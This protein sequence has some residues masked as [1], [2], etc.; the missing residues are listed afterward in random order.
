MIQMISNLDKSNHIPVDDW[1]TELYPVEDSD[2][3]FRSVRGEIILPFTDLFNHDEDARQLNYFIMTT[4][5]GYNSDKTREHICRYLNYFEKFYDNDKELLSILYEMKL[6]I[7]YNK[8]YNKSN[9]MADVNRYIIRNTNLCL[10][11][12]RFVDDNY[13]MKLSSY[14]N[15]TPNLQ[16][17]NSHA[18]VLYEISLLMNIYIP[19]AT[20]FIYVHSIKTSVQDFMLK[21]FDMCCTKY[22]EERGI[23]IY[24]KLYETSTSV[25][26]KS[27]NPDRILW[28]KNAIRGINTTTHI[29]ESVYDIILQII[30]KYDYKNNIINFNYYSNR[31]SVKFKVNKLPFTIA[32]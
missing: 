9:F 5:R 13:T 30:P 29:Q 28:E 14:N 20:H 17:T 24:D 27:K 1:D 12:R 6:C 19:L 2:R 23:Y 18:K 8:D 22:E 3:I 10:K 4:K 16:F 7:D 15:K 26:N 11:I 25:V 32:I 31:Q 21:L